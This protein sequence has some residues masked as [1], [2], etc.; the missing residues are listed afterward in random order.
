MRIKE[1]SVDGLNYKIPDFMNEF[2]QLMYVHLINWKWENITKEPGKY[3]F[4][5]EELENDIL[6]PQSVQH[7]YPLIYPGIHE[8]LIDYR[9]EGKLHNRFLLN[10]NNMASSQAAN[11]N[12]FLP[13]LLH[14]GVNSILRQI[15]PD[16]QYLATG[17]LRNG[18][19]I[20]CRNDDSICEPVNLGDHNSRMGTDVDLSISYFNTAGELCL[21]IIDHKFTEREF[22]ECPAFKNAGRDRERHKCSKSFSDILKNKSYCYYHDV[23][24]FRYWDM[25]GT[26]KEFFINHHQYES[27]PFRNGMN[28]LWRKHLLSMAMKES[29]EYS[30]VFFT[31]VKHPD[32][33][34]L[35]KTIRAYK[36]IIGNNPVFS[37]LDS[38]AVVSA[39]K[40]LNELKLNRWVEWY[41][42]LYALGS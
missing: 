17:K 5:G 15:K 3:L 33:R 39:G 21:W 8:D 7:N 31:V 9:D 28:E 1:V 18:F 37:I 4:K 32:N 42:G 13:V 36:Q 34:S 10:F 30:N 26:H 16:F 24:G 6:L 27:C 20:G 19:S 35:D 2:Q 12:L 29:G 38:G 14:P 11:I 41:R 22:I 23:K 25:T 40:A